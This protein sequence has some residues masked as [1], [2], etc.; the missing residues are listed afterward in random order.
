MIAF[1]LVSSDP[2]RT[3]GLKI[4]L[5]AVNRKHVT[6]FMYAFLSAD[7]DDTLY[8]YSSGIAAACGQNIKGTDTSCLFFVFATVLYVSHFTVFLFSN[9]KMNAFCFIF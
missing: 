5:V 9:C 3:F 1:C 4:Q 6:F 8:P 7:L 2:I